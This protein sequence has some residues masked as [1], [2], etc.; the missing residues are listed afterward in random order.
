M[1]TQQAVYTKPDA[2]DRRSPFKSKAALSWSVLAGDLAVVLA[3][4][5]GGDWLRSAAW[6]GTP[7][8]LSDWAATVLAAFAAY[9]ILGYGEGP[10]VGRRRG[11]LRVALIWTVAFLAVA[12][13]A[14]ALAGDVPR[15]SAGLA[16]WYLPSL[17]G[18]LVWRTLVAEALRSPRVEQLFAERIALVVDDA[19]ARVPEWLRRIQTAAGG[20]ARVVAL[21]APGY[22]AAVPDVTRAETITDLVLR[23]AECEV[24][25]IV[26][27]AP[28]TTARALFA[29][30]QP[31]RACAID[32]DAIANGYDP[33]IHQ[34]PAVSFAGMPAVRVVKR[35]LTDVQVAIKRAEDIA[36]ASLAILFLA[37]ALLAIAAAVKLSSPGPIIFR[38]HRHGFNHARFRVWKF[39]SMYVGAPPPAKTDL[40]AVAQAT[41]DDPRVTR[42]GRFL[43]RTSLDELPQLFNVLLGD[44]SMV[45]PRPHAVEHNEFY[46]RLIEN[47]MGRH[48][49]KP[50]I[51]GWAQVHGW[52]G[53]TADIEK[54]K[55]RVDYDLWYVDNWSP[56]LDLKIL[57][58]TF[59]VLWH[60]NAY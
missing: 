21:T 48:R 6:R 50:G 45:G 59:S 27:V 41:R 46:G 56:L 47:Y 35:P 14:Y 37:P 28:D 25:R 54:M 52:R 39:R 3:F 13:V 40:G 34:W 5:L 23:C 44:M 18:L 42:V 22:D 8:Q 4:S 30:L 36:L 9:Q 55:A 12:P 11:V 60:P 7:A 19:A 29:R 20:R 51:T 38:Q 1:S 26:V 49:M 57:L 53:E 31:L 24:E 10:R 15:A 32:V 16:G 43:R 33:D 2:P 58:M 17:F